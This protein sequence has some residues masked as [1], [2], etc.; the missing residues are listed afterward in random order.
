MRHHRWIGAGGAALLAIACAADASVG[1][2]DAAS[3]SDGASTLLEVGRMTGVPRPYAGPT[4]AANA[5]RGVPG[6][7]LPW[8]ISKGEAKL[9]EDGFLEVEVQGLVF[10]PND[11]TV[12]ERG[13]AGRNTVPGF[14][15]IVSCRTVEIVDGSPV[16]SVANV[17]TAVFP[18]TQGLASDGGGSAEIRQTIAVPSPCIAPIVFVTSPAGAWFAASGF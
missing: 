18:A 7:G 8:V 3:R 13:L 1:R 5:I 17:E 15:A 9:R 16:A 11:P 12:I 6:G 2:A 4:A 10:D 14:K